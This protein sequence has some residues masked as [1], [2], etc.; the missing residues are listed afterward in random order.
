MK[1]TEHQ[2]TESTIDTGAL[3]RRRFLV[4]SAGI[5]ALAAA[6]S[7]MTQRA[8]AQTARAHASWPPVVRKG[9]NM[10]VKGDPRPVLTLPNNAK[11]F[12][13]VTIAFEGFVTAGNYGMQN[14]KRTPLADSYEQYAY[15]YGVWRLL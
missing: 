5:T 1:D 6:Q 10:G 2:N 11:I 14:G 3:Q 9:T 7:L 12:V 4:S 8:A 13:S 15:D